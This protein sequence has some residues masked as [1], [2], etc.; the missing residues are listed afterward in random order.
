[1]G[2]F[3]F[4]LFFVAF[5]LIEYEAWAMD[6]AL[7]VTLEETN[8]KTAPRL[9]VGSFWSDKIQMAK[10]LSTYIST[11]QRCV[12]LLANSRLIVVPLGHFSK[13]VENGYYIY[14]YSLDMVRMY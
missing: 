3:L 10:S 8:G 2:Y 11:T 7:H 6:R 13:W 5:C 12:V 14:L 1:M 4:F 9:L